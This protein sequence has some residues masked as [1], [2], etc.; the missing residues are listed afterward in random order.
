M[1]A[2]RAV[3]PK[4]NTAVDGDATPIGPTHDDGGLRG[5]CGGPDWIP[6]VRKAYTVPVVDE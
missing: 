4:R 1:P 6:G 3:G 2:T 5:G